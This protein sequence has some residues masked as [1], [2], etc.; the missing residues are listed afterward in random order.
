MSAGKGRRKL[1][2]RYLWARKHRASYFEQ[3]TILL[4]L[5]LT[6]PHLLHLLL[7]YCQQAAATPSS[8]IL[9]LPQPLPQAAPCSYNLLTL[10]SSLISS[11]SHSL[12]FPFCFLIAF[13]LARRP[14]PQPL[15]TLPV[16][17][18]S[19]RNSWKREA[20]DKGQCQGCVCTRTSL[21]WHSYLRILHMVTYFQEGSFFL[22]HRGSAPGT[23]QQQHHQWNCFHS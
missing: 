11:A 9:P 20:W 6:L 7:L 10:E 3:V 21:S 5:F 17:P 19:L 13:L 1:V 2:D 12:L 8:F 14:G 22:W 18:E 16:L 15:L 4:H 23:A